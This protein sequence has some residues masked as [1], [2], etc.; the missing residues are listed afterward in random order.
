LERLLLVFTFDWIVLWPGT[1]EGNLGYIG[2]N[3]LFHHELLPS[4]L[5]D[6]ELNDIF[7]ACLPKL[8]K[9]A[10]KM[11]RNQQDSEDALQDGLLLAFRNLH[12]FQGRSAFS[13]W[14]HSIVRNCSRMHYRKAATQDRVFVEVATPLER[15]SFAEAKCIDLRPSP[16]ELCIQSDR[17]NILR[18]TSRELPA[19]YRAAFNCFHLED[20]GERETARKLGISCTAVKTRLHRS[21]RF[22]TARIRGAHL[23]AKRN[24]RAFCRAGNHRAAE[25]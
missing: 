9:A 24:G 1:S 14:L 19:S 7:A 2:E 10:Q 6:T 20:L 5:S 11:L 13:T 18:K 17:S 15:P 23:P 25:Q 8:K 3:A 22:L 16:E 4:Q 12:Q 21:R